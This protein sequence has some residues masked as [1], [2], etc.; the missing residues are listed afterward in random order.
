MRIRRRKSLKKKNVVIVVLFLLPLIGFGTYASLVLHIIDDMASFTF[1]LEAPET[2]NFYDLSE[3]DEKRLAEMAGI[4]ETRWDLYHS[5]ANIS[6]DCTFTDY[7]YTEVKAWIPTDNGGQWTGMMLASECLRYKAATNANDDVEMANSMKLIRKMVSCFSNFLAAPNGGIGPDYPGIPARY[8]AAPGH[9]DICPFMFEDDPIHYNGTGIYHN[10]RVRLYT[11]LDEMAGYIQGL[12]SVLKFIDPEDS[13]TAKWCYERTRLLITQLIEGFKKTNWL[14]ISGDGNPAGTTISGSWKLV[15]LKMGALSYPDKYEQEYAYCAAKELS[16]GSSQGSSWNVIMDYY[17]LAFGIC[18]QWTLIILE[19]IPEIRLIHIKNFEEGIF[20]ICKY[21]RNAFVNIA[22]LTFM[23]LLEEEEKKQFNN[24]I[25]DD[26]DIKW[27]VLDQ[28]WRFHASGWCPIRNYNLAQRPHST[29]STS[30]DKTIREAE[31][32]QTSEKWRSFFEN[33]MFGRAYSWVDIEFDFD[34]HY[35]MPLTISEMGIDALIWEENPFFDE[36][37][38]P[39]GDGL[40]ENTGMSYL[41]VYWMGKA[42]NIF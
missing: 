23:S 12:G 10:W 19:D 21:H 16:Q 25:Y 6:V 27:D 29:R 17:A 8:V 26:N 34:D 18:V 40:T 4:M 41:L 33:N 1:E 35:T 15:L 9:E 38:N 24:P 2:D 14:M 30:R 36:G 5:P 22:H 3:I 32:D 7:S 42:Y 37:G 11:S 39:G 13:E 28:L 31:K 20:N